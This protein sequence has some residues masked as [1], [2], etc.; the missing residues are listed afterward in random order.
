MKIVVTGSHGTGKSSFAKGLAEKLG[1]KYIH[2]I[3]TDEIAP[4]GFTINEK[5][6]P[7]VQIMLI[8]HQW[9]LE[10]ITPQPWVADKCL[11]D[12]WVYS[13]EDF[14]DYIKK[15]IL[16]FI[17]GNAPYDFVFYLPVEFPMELNEWR[18]PDLGFQKEMDRRYKKFLD[19]QGIKY[20]ILPSFINES[21]SKEEAI[22]K[23]INLAL[24]YI[25]N[26]QGNQE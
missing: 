21:A 14:E 7:E 4:Q 2:D 1:A 26:S 5:T 17:N 19:E 6:P 20:I 16:M 10:Q 23:R 11:Y 18:S 3:V 12:Y 25:K 22:K 9:R 24:D 15:T 13:R 8:S